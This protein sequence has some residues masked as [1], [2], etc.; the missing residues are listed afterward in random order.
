[1]GSPSGT[2]STSGSTPVDVDVVVVV[3]VDGDGD[4]DGDTTGSGGAPLATARCTNT[5]VVIPAASKN[6]PITAPALANPTIHTS[7]F[8]SRATVLT[9]EYARGD[10][11]LPYRS[12]AR[13]AARTA[14]DR[15][16]DLV[17]RDA[18][19]GGDQRGREARPSE[20]IPLPEVHAAADRGIELFLRLD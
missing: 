7:G 16:G 8:R 9:P 4:V 11:F 12:V 17:E 10:G 2:T 15:A 5:Q 13:R 14:P 18:A 3:D 1:M 19:P 20:E 6:A